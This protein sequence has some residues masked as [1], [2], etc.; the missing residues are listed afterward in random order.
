MATHGQ[1]SGTT[2]TGDTTETSLGTLTVTQKATAIVGVWCYA[3]G[4]AT[5]TSGEAITGVYRLSSGDFDIAPFSLPLHLVSIVSNGAVGFN[6]QVMPVEVG[7]VSGGVLE[8]LVTM[9]MAHTGALVG[10]WGILTV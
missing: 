2:A 10:R 3:L 4:G 8:V 6:I 1:S 5:M 7:G 9:D